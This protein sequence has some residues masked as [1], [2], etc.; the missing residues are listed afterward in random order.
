MYTRASFL[1]SGVI[2]C[3]NVQSMKRCSSSHERNWISCCSSGRA[4][5]LF[6]IHEYLGACRRPAPIGR[7][8]TM[9]RRDFSPRIRCG[10]RR[11]PSA[12]SENKSALGAPGIQ[13]EQVV[14]QRGIFTVLHDSLPHHTNHRGTSCPIHHGYTWVDMRT[15]MRRDRVYRHARWG[16]YTRQR[17]TRRNLEVPDILPRDM[18]G[19]GCCLGS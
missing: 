19:L 1:L 4:P 11:S 10:R 9:P 15:A 17:H 3:A 18:A 7:Y 12:C 8:L 6:S 13:V 14:V 16:I 2:R 5:H